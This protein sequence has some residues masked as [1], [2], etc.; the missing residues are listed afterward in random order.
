MDREAGV[1]VTH[2]PSPDTAGPEGQDE[3][4]DEFAPYLAEQM[5]RPNFRRY[6]AR[7]EQRAAQGHQFPMAYKPSRRRPGWRRTR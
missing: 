5:E 7:A 1:P 2:V 6:Y 3:W 4:P